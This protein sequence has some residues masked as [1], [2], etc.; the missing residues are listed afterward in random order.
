MIYLSTIVQGHLIDDHTNG[1]VDLEA[2]QHDHIFDNAWPFMASLFDMI[3]AK[4]RLRA[5]AGPWGIHQL[6]P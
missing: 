4:V 6:L 5:E 1:L 3:K 2:S